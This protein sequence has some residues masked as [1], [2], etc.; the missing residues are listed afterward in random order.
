VKD[1]ITTLT[2]KQLL[3]CKEYCIDFNGARAAIAAGY[4]PKHA[5]AIAYENLSR[6][7]I[8][9]YLNNYIKS[10]VEVAENKAFDVI[11]KLTELA[12]ANPDDMFEET[13]QEVVKELPNG[14][15][16]TFL[17]KTKQIKPGCMKYFRHKLVNG[18]VISEQIDPTK[19]LELLGK[20]Q[21]IYVDKSKVELSVDEKMQKA[22][23]EI[24]R[25]FG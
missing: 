10:R 14:D 1:K 12:T 20:T 13:E 9:E 6:P 25:K 5:K 7:H 17:N 19:T 23:D 15:N 18:K 4:T 8:A 2:P 21:G 16:L 11:G 3:F 24:V 22:I